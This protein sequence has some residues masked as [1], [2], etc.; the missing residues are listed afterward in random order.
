NFY[1]DIES[2]DVKL[3]VA[4][5]LLYNDLS[6]EPESLIE[7][8]ILFFLSNHIFHPTL[9]SIC[10]RYWNDNLARLFLTS[11]VE[12]NWNDVNAQMFEKYTNFFLNLI[13]KEQLETF[14]QEREKK[15]SYLVKRIYHIWLENHNIS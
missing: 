10:K 12:L 4:S 5:Y 7:E 15:V 2:S 8:Y 3:N 14:E 1:N 11:F 13:T 9:E 6:S